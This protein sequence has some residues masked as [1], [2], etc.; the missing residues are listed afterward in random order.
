MEFCLYS[1][2]VVYFL[3]KKLYESFLLKLSMKNEQL[4]PHIIFVKYLRLFC[5]Q[6]KTIY[7]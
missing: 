7:C 6:A 2:I 3:A 4:P 1:K 5:L